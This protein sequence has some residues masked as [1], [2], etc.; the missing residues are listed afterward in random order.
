MSTGCW[1]DVSSYV[2][3]RQCGTNHV[4][5]PTRPSPHV[6]RTNGTAS[7]VGLQL[8]ISRNGGVIAAPNGRTSSEAVV[9]SDDD[10]DIS[11]DFEREEQRRQHMSEARRHL[12]DH[13][14]TLGGETPENIHPLLPQPLFTSSFDSPRS[15]V[16]SAP[17]SPVPTGESRVPNRP[18]VGYSKPRREYKFVRSRSSS[19]NLSSPS[20]SPPRSPRRSS[21]KTY[22]YRNEKNESAQLVMLDKYIRENPDQSAPMKRVREELLREREQHRYAGE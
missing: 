13:A 15:S 14:R 5:K 20:S 17:T 10:G 22:R 19:S 11:I 4:G 2:D 21:S 3:L 7:A 12:N 6:R 16:E 18:D 8:G 1:G 9:L